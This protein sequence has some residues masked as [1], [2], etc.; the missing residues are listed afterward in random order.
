M[1]N[2]KT[3]TE[4]SLTKPDIYDGEDKAE[5]EYLGD[6]RTQAQDYGQKLQDAAIKARDY[7][8]EKFSVASDK[9]K[10]LQQKEPQ[11]LVNDAK[12]YARQKPGQTILIS[13]A[14]GLVVGFLLRNRK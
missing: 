2:T 8:N 3:K 4:Q 5:N 14:V 7:A 13:A 1:E 12:E 11:E 10:E 9:F 6:I